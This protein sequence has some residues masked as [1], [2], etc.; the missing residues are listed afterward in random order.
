MLNYS[1]P[2]A[3]SSLADLY[4][5]SLVVEQLVRLNLSQ[6]ISSYSTEWRLLCHIGLLSFLFRIVEKGLLT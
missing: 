2:P 3:V 6:G 4:R 5:N 1:S